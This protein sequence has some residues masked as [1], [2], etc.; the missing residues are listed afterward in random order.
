MKVD[1]WPDWSPLG[2]FDSGSLTTIP[3]LLTPSLPWTYT[4]AT[5]QYYIQVKVFQPR[6]I[7]L[8]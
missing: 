3:N 6:L 2:V 8:G 4:H 5:G 1:P 7:L